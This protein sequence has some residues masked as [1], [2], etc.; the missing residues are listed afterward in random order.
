M[1]A[2]KR[3]VA[4][5]LTA[6]LAAPLSLFA[7]SRT[8]QRTVTAG[9]A[10]TILSARGQTGLSVPHIVAAMNRERAA[11]GLSPL[12][13]NRQ[14]S[15]AANDRVGDMFAKR[16]FDHVAPDG[17]QPFEWVGKRG[18]AYRTIGENLA[19]GFRSADA[20]VGGWMRS[21]GHR[22]NIL[23][24]HFDEVGVAVADGSPIRGYGGPLVVAMYGSR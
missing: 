8:R 20:I 6:A 3:F 4:I 14:L 5:A 12:R 17:T 16:Y 2:T 19:T 9:V 15:L 24:R 10:Q 11:Y 18:Y 1:T 21:P 22:A 13:L 23:G 7:D